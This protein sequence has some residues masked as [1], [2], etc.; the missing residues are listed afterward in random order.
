MNK[1]D[2]RNFM[3][4]PEGFK[5]W[6]ADC[7]FSSPKDAADKLG[8]K[9]RTYHRYKSHGIPDK[10]QRETVLDRMEQALRKARV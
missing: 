8:V 5:K 2:K 3:S 9:L 6:E 1:L 10:L 4:T 7:G